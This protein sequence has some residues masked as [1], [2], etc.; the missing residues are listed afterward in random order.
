[1]GETKGHK[2]ENHILL[3]ATAGIQ[4]KIY[5]YTTGVN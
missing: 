1:M 2:I 3:P 4:V 5:P